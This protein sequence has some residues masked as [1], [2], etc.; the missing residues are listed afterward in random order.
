MPSKLALFPLSGFHPSSLA[1]LSTRL[2][3][4]RSIFLLLSLSHAALEQTHDVDHLAAGLAYRR[5]T[6]A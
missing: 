3:P 6:I 5:F 4:P 2:T 1:C